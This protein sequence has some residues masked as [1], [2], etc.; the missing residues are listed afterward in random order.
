MRV[1]L[2][3]SLPLG[4]GHSFRQRAQSLSVRRVQALIIATGSLAASTPYLG[5]ILLVIVF[6]WLRA[7]T[8]LG[9]EFEA[10]QVRV[11]RFG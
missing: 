9:N 3:R 2:T 7:V 5:G 8:R 11:I 10:L 4:N 1:H 6:S